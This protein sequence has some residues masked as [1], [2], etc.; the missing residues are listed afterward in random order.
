MADA[1]V[2]KVL[3]ALEMLLGLGI[4]LFGP[5]TCS[6]AGLY[7]GAG[8][9]CAAGYVIVGV[10]LVAIGLPQL[11]TGAAL[12]ASRRW[13]RP[14]ALLSV[15]LA[16]LVPALLVALGIRELLAGNGPS[17]TMLIGLVTL[18]PYAWLTWRLVSRHRSVDE[19][20]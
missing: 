20:S 15:A 16:A 3:G 5:G 19:A 7:V 13:G 14:A 6:D 2:L 17:L 10:V 1:S 11:L 9:L 18:S 8:G 12:A 4:A